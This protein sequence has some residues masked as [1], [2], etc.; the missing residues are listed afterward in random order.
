MKRPKLEQAEKDLQ[1]LH[2]ELAE[3]GGPSMNPSGPS[4][5]RRS[6]VA[7]LRRALGHVRDA[8]RELEPLPDYVKPPPAEG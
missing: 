6:A 4:Y 7:A 1:K 3:R 2:D 8:Q 5:S